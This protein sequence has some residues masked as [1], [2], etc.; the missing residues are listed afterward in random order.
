MDPQIVENL[1]HAYTNAYMSGETLSRIERQ[2]LIGSIA[3]SARRVADRLTLQGVDKRLIDETIQPL[4]AAISRE[5]RIGH[6]A[7]RIAGIAKKAGSDAVA[8]AL[9]TFLATGLAGVGVLV[10]ATLANVTGLFTAIATA[11]SSAGQAAGQMAALALATLPAYALFRGL[12]VVVNNLQGSTT[13]NPVAELWN[14]AS[15]I[16]QDAEG[17]LA[18]HL[19]PAESALFKA[20]PPP[21]TTLPERIRYLAKGLT[22]VT[23]VTFAIAA[24]LFLVAAV[25]G[26]NSARENRNKVGT[27]GSPS[28]R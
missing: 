13:T 14:S 3:D 19:H 4:I 5:D 22:I 16:G 27:F 8:G 7:S 10:A 28:S 9:G 1:K 11:I 25:D 2:I 6:A 24:V 17:V 26:F 15:S 12:A 21:S 20:G 18:M 23:I